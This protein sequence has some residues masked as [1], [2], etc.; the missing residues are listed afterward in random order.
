MPFQQGGHMFDLQGY[1]QQ[2]FG[3]TSPY[4]LIQSAGQAGVFSPYGSPAALDAIRMQYQ[5]QF[6][7]AAGA[8]RQRAQMAAGNDPALAAWAG[9]NAGMQGQSDEANALSD[10]WL[11]SILGNQQFLQQGVYQPYQQNR[12]ALQQLQE[13][14]K[15]Q[16]ELQSQGF[17]G[18]MLGGL[19]SLGG[20]MLMG[21]IPGLFGAGAGAG[22]NPFLLGSPLPPVPF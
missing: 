11:R 7:P 14:G 1:G 22:Y 2:N 15:Q 20:S 16:R 18:Q 3:P 8:A 5:R 12:Y 6:G 19:G 21:G 4:G 13:M 17:M 10:A 9:L